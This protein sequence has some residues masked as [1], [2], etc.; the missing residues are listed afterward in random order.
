MRFHGAWK[1]GL[2][3]GAALLGL[4]GCV[5]PAPGYGYYGYGYGEPAYYPYYGGPPVYGS[6]WVGGGG[7]HHHH[8]R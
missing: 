4:S 1:I 3:L 7:W 6:V 2:L 5:Y 8:W